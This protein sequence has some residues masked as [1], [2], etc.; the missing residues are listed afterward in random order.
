MNEG[1]K[2]LTGDHDKMNPRRKDSGALKEEQRTNAFYYM[3][4]S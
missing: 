4:L 1:I 3:A 2:Y